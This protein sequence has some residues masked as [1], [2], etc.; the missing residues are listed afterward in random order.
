MDTQAHVERAKILKED[1]KTFLEQRNRFNP[2]TATVTVTA[3]ASPLREELAAT[4]SVEK[5][6]ILGVISDLVCSENKVVMFPVTG[7]I[8]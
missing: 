8:T 7:H 2:H 4:P 3:L 5:K 6:K 1:L